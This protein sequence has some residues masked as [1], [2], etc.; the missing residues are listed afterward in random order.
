MVLGNGV[1]REPQNDIELDVDDDLLPGYPNPGLNNEHIDNFVVQDLEFDMGMD[2]G[3]D[4]NPNLDFNL[5]EE[6]LFRRETP[7]MSPRRRRRSVR[8]KLKKVVRKA[9]RLFD[10]LNRDDLLGIGAH[11]REM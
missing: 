1:F 2:I 6:N 5:T 10:E 7:L 11:D 9:H 3:N 8:R 4:F